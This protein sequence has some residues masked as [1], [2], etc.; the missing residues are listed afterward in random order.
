MSQHLSASAPSLFRCASTRSH[1]DD[2]HAG[3]MNSVATSRA[4]FDSRSRHGHRGYLDAR[5]LSTE[6]YGMNERGER[7]EDM[8]RGRH[9]WSKFEDWVNNNDRQLC[10]ADEVTAVVR[11]QLWYEAFLSRYW[12]I[13]EKKYRQRTR[14]AHTF[15]AEVLRDIKA[16]ITQRYFEEASAFADAC[17]AVDG[18]LALIDLMKHLWR[19]LGPRAKHD[20]KVPD[21]AGLTQVPRLR[22]QSLEKAVEEEKQRLCRKLNKAE[23]AAIAR[24]PVVAFVAADREGPAGNEEGGNAHDW[25]D[26]LRDADPAWTDGHVS[27]LEEMISQEESD[28]FRQ[29]MLDVLQRQATKVRKVRP[30]RLGGGHP[31]CRTSGQGRK[32]RATPAA[33]R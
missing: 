28:A 15:D 11:S 17:E 1:C 3:R 6:R 30:C 5:G 13:A 32:L 4:S 25:L 14:H 26:I 27:A 24:W 9:Y 16:D 23:R 10:N 2:H 31:V 33:L 7:L 18:G 8:L 12:A 19:K 22:G 29:I 21:F 20:P